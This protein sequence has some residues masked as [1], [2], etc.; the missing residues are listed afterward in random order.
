MLPVSARA[1]WLWSRQIIPGVGAIRTIAYGGG[2]FVAGT[3][4]GYMLSSGDAVHWTVARPTT[5]AINDI[6]FGTRRY[7]RLDGCG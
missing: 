4:S 2:I 6:V 7:T 5:L 1:D 3:N